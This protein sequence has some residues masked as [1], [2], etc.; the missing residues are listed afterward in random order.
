MEGEGT[1][2][3]IRLMVFK[4]NF[5]ESLLSSSSVGLLLSASCNYPAR[6]R[7]PF[8][9]SQCLLACLLFL[10]SF[11]SLCIHRDRI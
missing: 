9:P 1:K 11:V 8:I 10:L 4:Q 5:R 2:L 3:C 7:I 6:P